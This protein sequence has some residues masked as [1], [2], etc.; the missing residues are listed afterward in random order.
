MRCHTGGSAA[1]SWIS[2][3][4]LSP[5]CPPGLP[6]PQAPRWAQRFTTP[7]E[8]CSQAFN[9]RPRAPSHAAIEWLIASFTNTTGEHKLALETNYEQRSDEKRVSVTAIHSQHNRP[10]KT[11]ANNHT[12]K[13]KTAAR[14]L[15]QF[16]VRLC[17]GIQKICCPLSATPK[18]STKSE[19]TTKS[20]VLNGLPLEAASS[21]AP[22]ELVAPGWRN[23][24]QS[25]RNLKKQEVYSA[26]VSPKHVQI[27]TCKTAE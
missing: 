24:V 23:E 10:G 1:R 3:R 19:T 16:F 27:K 14:D 12:Q 2:H 6:R 5:P 25:E 17:V 21:A 8:R 15:Q 4:A 9:T 22:A 20:F 7:E 18:L 13:K 11:L 26:Y